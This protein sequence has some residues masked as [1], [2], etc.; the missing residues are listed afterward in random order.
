M[1]QRSSLEVW[2]YRLLYVSFVIA[3]IAAGL[4]KFYYYM[5]Q[6][7]KYL[8]PIIPR[9]LF[10]MDPRAIMTLVGVVEVGAG[11]LVAFRPRIGAM[12]V[13]L[14]LFGIVVNLLLTQA[15][16]DIALRD[17]GLALAALS[18]AVIS[19]ECGWTRCHV[20]SY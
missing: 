7:D 5:V 11:V 4:D 9:L 14:W 12:I 13:A 1:N 3:P 6:W 16:Y 17:F 10:N 8:A 2:A 20:R 15:Y 18:F 19:R